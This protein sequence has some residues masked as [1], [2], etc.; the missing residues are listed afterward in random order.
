MTSEQPPHADNDPAPA[1]PPPVGTT[2]RPGRLRLVLSI[3]IPLVAIAVIAVLARVVGDVPPP[4]PNAPLAVG[5]VFQ[6]GSATPACE[7]LDKA[8]PQTLSELPRRTLYAEE[9]GV[10]G[11]GQGPVVYRCGIETPTSLKC[12]SALTTVSGVSWLQL[13]ESGL[14]TYIAVDR[15]VRV[16]LTLP[17]GTG[18]GPIQALST[19]IAATL[20]AREPCVNGALVPTDDAT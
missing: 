7:K 14:T 12:D 2:G 15:S 16:A 6:P 4:D 1:A 18:S 19:V 13:S 17:D 20:P 3:G 5:V 9:P 8:L 10:A 11:W